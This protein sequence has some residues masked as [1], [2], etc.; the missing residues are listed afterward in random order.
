MLDPFEFR[1]YIEVV[2]ND[3]H[4]A[5]AKISEASSKIFLTCS[6]PRHYH[7]NIILADAL[8]NVPAFQTADIWSRHNASSF[9]YRF[10]H[11]GKRR[12][13]RHFLP[14]SA[15]VGNSSTGNTDTN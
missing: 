15:L 3:V 11:N 4:E 13:G 12:K 7:Y 8:F 6:L 2:R 5:L 1:K 9:L 14:S 10:G